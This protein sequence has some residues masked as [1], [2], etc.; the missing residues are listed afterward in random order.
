MPVVHHP[1]GT[2]FPPNHPFATPTIIFGIKRPEPHR[3]ENNQPPPTE[4]PSASQTDS[5]SSLPQH[6]ASPAKE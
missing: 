4:P 6:G 1:P 5:T 3:Q 2:P